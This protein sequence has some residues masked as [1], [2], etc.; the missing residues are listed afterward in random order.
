MIWWIFG[1]IVVLFLIY[2]LIPELIFHLCHMDTLFCGSQDNRQIALTFDDGPDVRYTPKLLD[3]LKES[4]IKATFFIVA[5]NALKHPELVQRMVAE[6]H[7]VGSHSYH[8]RHAWLRTPVGTYRDIAKAKQSIE[9]I[10]RQDVKYYRSP[11]GAMNLFT[12]WSCRKLG[13]KQVL[14]SLR[15]MDWKSGEYVEDIVYRLVR[16]AHPGG[17]VLCH[18]AGGAK[19]ST[20]NMVGALPLVIHQLKQLGFSFTTVDVLDV[21]QQSKHQKP[22]LYQGYPIFRRGLIALWQ[23]VEFWFA[24]QYRVLPLNA[25][26]RVSR[27]TWRFGSRDLTQTAT[28]EVG[29][30]ADGSASVDLHFQNNTLVA[31][32][33]ENDNRALIRAL[34]L[35]KSGLVDVGRVLLYHPDYQDVQV[36]AAVTLMNRGL[37]MLGFHVED[38]PKTSENTRLER[39]MRFLMGMYH[40]EGFR[41]LGKGTKRPTLKLVW[42]TKE[43]L[44]LRYPG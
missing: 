37:E 21:A 14:W 4:G 11:W 31:I 12:H 40:P 42:M 1:A 20:E 8:H 3:T 35:T 28:T 23:V 17:I 25:I 32:S 15:A 5:Q 34:R 27:S 6:G 36:I 13:H 16:A 29:Q 33:N 24:K 43:E 7:V 39:Y 38:L 26:F 22:P 10:V 19:G 41:R 30:I 18:D 2:C 9:A 44:L